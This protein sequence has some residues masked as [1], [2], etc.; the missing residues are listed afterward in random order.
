[1]PAGVRDGDQIQVPGVDRRFRIEVG[2]RPRDSRAVLRLAAV[3]L[4]CALGL[5]LYLLVR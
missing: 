3:M 5:L 1:V 2:T 4:V